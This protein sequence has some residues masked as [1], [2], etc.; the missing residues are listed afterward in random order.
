MLRNKVVK[1]D[2]DIFYSIEKDYDDV[3]FDGKNYM[4]KY[5][6]TKDDEYYSYDRVRTY[7]F[8]D[9]INSCFVV[10]NQGMVMNVVNKDLF[11][12]KNM[13][14]IDTRRK[15]IVVIKSYKYT[16]ND[17]NE[18]LIINKYLA[19]NIVM[20]NDTAKALFRTELNKFINNNDK[21]YFTFRMVSFVSEKDLSENKKYFDY[22]LDGYITKNILDF[23][24]DFYT[25]YNQ[26]TTSLEITLKDNDVNNY[27]MVI[28]NEIITL[29]TSDTVTE[30]T[31]RYKHGNHVIKE[32]RLKDKHNDF[33]IYASE[34]EAKV[35]LDS[36]KKRD[37][38]LNLEE[39]KLDVEDKKLNVELCK[40]A[41]ELKKVQLENE[42]MKFEK[43]KMLIDKEKA[44]LDYKKSIINYKTEVL[45]KELNTYNLIRDLLKN[46]PVV[47]DT[48]K[49]IISIFKGG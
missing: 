7:V 28:K 42:K 20:L 15:G 27:F 34:R 48:I 12:I 18:L 30:D 5:A 17:V 38:K 25:N 41:G 3:I 22:L 10:D 19:H 47:R 8:K 46:G 14:K 49:S 2:G 31:I 36:N 40:L 44:F 4:G 16:R 13:L 9:F 11:H 37:F 23:N 32:W 21:F 29:N 24:K 39:K 26:G 43:I 1:M 45:K 35:N 6:I 33:N